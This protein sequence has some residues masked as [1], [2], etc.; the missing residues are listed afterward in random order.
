[1]KVIGKTGETTYLI[2]ATQDE[3]ANILGERSLFDL[4]HRD[5]YPKDIRI[6][7]EIHPHND[8]NRLDFLVRNR[9]RGLEQLADQCRRVLKAIEDTGPLFTWDR[10]RE[11]ETE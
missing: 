9:D 6:G 5:K 4:K 7:T 11:G 1:M 2:E 8:W 3:I 10:N